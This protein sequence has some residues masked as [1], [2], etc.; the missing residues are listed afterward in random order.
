M[1][2]QIHLFCLSCHRIIALVHSRYASGSGTCCRLSHSVFSVFYDVMSWMAAPSHVYGGVYGSFI[3]MVTTQCLGRISCRWCYDIKISQLTKN[4]TKGSGRKYIRHLSNNDFTLNGTVWT[5]KCHRCVLVLARQCL[6]IV[7]LSV[8]HLFPISWHRECKNVYA[9]LPRA[10]T[11][12]ALLEGCIGA[13]G[14][15]VPKAQQPSGQASGRY[16]IVSS[17]HGPGLRL[18]FFSS[19][20]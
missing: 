8:C 6:Q 13:Q 15:E 17:R 14:P 20:S 1:A 2:S 9:C 11:T 12:F 3:A 19:M 5:K 4:I 16:Y 7:F 18:V 10:S